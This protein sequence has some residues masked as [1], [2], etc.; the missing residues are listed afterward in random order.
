V[1]TVEKDT[2]YKNLGDSYFNIG[3]LDKA[4]GNYEK[5]LKIN[6]HNDE[7]HYN[8]AVSLYMQQNY[9]IARTEVRK[10]IEMQPKN[11]VYL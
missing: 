2:S 6:S 8:L 5:S 3:M 1:R 4:I 9:E 11:E 7:C 10:A